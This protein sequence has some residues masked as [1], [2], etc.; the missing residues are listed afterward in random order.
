[1]TTDLAI[2]LAHPAGEQSEIE[3][4]SAIADTFG[5]RV[6]VEWDAAEPVTPLGQLPFFVEY[7]KQGGL[8][9]GWVADCPLSFTS[10][11]AP[12]KRDVLG[13]LLL[14]V[15]AGHQR[16][17]HITALRCDPVNPPLLGMRK[18]VSEDAVRRGLA[19]I[20]ETAGMDWL[21]AHLDYCVS[22]LLQ[23]PWVLDV[24]TTIKPLY[25]T[26]EGAVVGYNPRKPGRPS[27]CYHTYMMSTLRL[28]LSVDVQPGD[29]HN[30]KHASDGLWSLLDRLGRSRWPALLR[31][32]SQW[33][34]EP[35]MAR[36]E[37][38]GM[39]YLFRLR[40]TR[41][42]NR[43]LQKAMLERDWTDAGQ[44]WQGKETS[45]RLMGWSRQ[46]RVILLRRKLDRPLAVV[47]RT[48][49]AL[50]QLSF[51]EVAGKR[52]VWEYAALVTSLHSEI[53]TLGQLY[54]DRADCENGFDELKNQWGWG[55][56]TTQD[57]KRCRLLA[58]SVALIYNWW[59]LFVR[60]ADPVHRRE[61]IT[62]RPLLLQAIARQTRHAGQVTLTISSAHGE[63]HKARRA[64]VRVAGFFA[65]LRQ[66]AEQMDPVQRWYR[67]LSEALRRF[68]HG[69][70]LIPP[71]RLEPA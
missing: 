20:D 31:G 35:V 55:G 59:S 45:L 14:S 26:Q 34:N 7:L 8:F 67:I 21:Q 33:G 19:K 11:N 57:L 56:F 68:L 42:V 64:Y 18:V 2:A 50:P 3:E 46:R 37:R 15:L 43:A 48:H 49:P 66:T 9:D 30:V 32:D 22:P 12:H 40:A 54:R 1:M 10:P 61:A 5:G 38:E 58:R 6:H 62:S 60:L 28:V 70:Q 39:P 71:A 53:L 29:Q 36:A 27:H 17:A 13:T 65:R 47:D 51:A 52:E 24:D 23:E 25:G 44:G 4:W 69:R 63:R 16:Y 41:N